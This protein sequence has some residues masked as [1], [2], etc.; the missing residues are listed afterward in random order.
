M[1]HLNLQLFPN[2][3]EHQNLDADSL[4]APTPASALPRTSLVLGLFYKLPQGIPRL[5]KQE[6]ALAAV[7]SGKADKTK[8]QLQSSWPLSDVW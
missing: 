1:P 4:P 8:G 6:A 3:A 2:P 7:G 5:E